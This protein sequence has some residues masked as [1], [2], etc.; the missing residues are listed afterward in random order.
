MSNSAISVRRA[1]V[2]LGA[3]VAVGVSGVTV[4]AQANAMP[5][6]ERAAVQRL[7]A[8]LTPSGDPNGTGEARFTL[9][10]ARQRVCAD[11]EWRRIGPPNAAHIHRQSDGGI[12]VDLTGSVTGAA[13][14]E[15]GVSRGLIARIIAHPGRYYFNVHNAAYP[16]GAIQGRLRR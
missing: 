5:A 4:G 13:R 11:V 2:A 7:Q 6:Q 14:C 15:T 3:S 12:V 1:A 10:R 8:Q 9:N 16:D